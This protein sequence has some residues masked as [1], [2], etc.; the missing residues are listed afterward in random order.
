L[1]LKSWNFSAEAEI[2]KKWTWK[3]RMKIDLVCTPHCCLLDTTTVTGSCWGE[4]FVRSGCRAFL[5]RTIVRVLVFFEGFPFPSIACFL[6]CWGWTASIRTFSFWR[7]NRFE[8]VGK[9]MRKSCQSEWNNSV[10]QFFLSLL[11]LTSN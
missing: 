1:S 4:Y 10:V 5:D 6:Y 11:H 7:S 3:R 2:Q 9:S 8:V